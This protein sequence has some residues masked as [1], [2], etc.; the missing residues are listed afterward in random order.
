MVKE[1]FKPFLEK[2]GPSDATQFIGKIGDLFYDPNT[3]ALR[4]SDGFTPGG[5]LLGAL[6]STGYVGTFY[7]TTVQTNPVASTPNAIT[8][9]SVN[10]SDGV[11]IVNSSRIKLLHA[12]NF[13]IQFSAQVDKTD[14]GSDEIDIWLRKNGNDI[15][16]S[17]TRVNI[18]GNNTKSV[19]AWNWVE[20]GLVND[21][22][23]IMWSSPDTFIRL[24]AQPAQS[25]PTRPGIPSV[26]L[27]VCQV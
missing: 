21:Y 5:T 9:N 12:G 14:S 7:D 25:S 19:V 17:N 4:L 27:T 2:L 8:F 22:Y 6:G 10:V 20:A 1:V 11:Q 15:P 24:Y 3:G 26:I 13:N 18:D 23:E 16:W